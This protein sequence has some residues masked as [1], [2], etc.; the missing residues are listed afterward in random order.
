[1]K[2]RRFEECNYKAVYHN[3]V[4]I[5]S[6]FDSERAITELPYPEFWDIKITNR[7]NA[8]PGCP[9]CYMDS[10]ADKP[11]GS[12]VLQ[13]FIDF[14]SVMD[15]NQRPFQIAFGGGEPTIHPEFP[16]IIEAC[17]NLGIV[18][19]YTTNGTAITEDIAN[20][21]KRF[22]DGVAISTHG[23]LNW[24]AGV[25]KLLSCN[26][27]FKI[28]FHT[29]I[30]DKKSIDDFYAIY[31][32]YEN[33]N[34]PYFVLLP[35]SATGR[36]TGRTIVVDTEYL[37]KI[38]KRCDLKRIAFGAHFYEFLKKESLFNRIV[39]LYEPEIFSKF[40]DLTTMKI[41]KNSFEVNT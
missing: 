23:Q 33:K 38:L 15:V 12:G 10:S 30:S 14:F 3:G 11:L 35:L 31:K 7:C 6:T 9:Y 39:S 27:K 21:T 41:Y 37:K 36:A 13:K 32:E 5:R 1:M 29:I 26:G 28:N 25:E 20:I 19:N 17:H 16:A 40:L 18:P 8:N 22:C 2:I 24:R 4:T 34:I